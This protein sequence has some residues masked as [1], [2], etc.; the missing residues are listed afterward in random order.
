M[1]EAIF[2]MEQVTQLYRKGKTT[3][4]ANDDITLDIRRGEI[5]GVLGPNGAGK[6][7]LIKQLVGHL[8]PT[9]G[10]VLYNG[11]DV[12]KQTNTVASEVAYY[13]QEPHV[14]S[15]LKVMEALVF[16]ARLR[17]MEA[18]AAKLEAEELLERFEMTAM[19]EKRLSRLSGGQKRMVGI[20]TT[21]IGHCPVLILD[22]PTNELDPKKRRMVWELIEERNRL[23]ATVILVTHNVLEAEH[24]VD[25]A[26]VINHGRLLAMDSVA[27][28]KQRVD[29]RLKFDIQTAFGLR[30]EVE[31]VLSPWGLKQEGTENRIRLLVDKAQ[32][33][34][35]LAMIISRTDLPIEEYAVLPPS[36]E[37]VYF[38][39]DQQAEQGGAI[40]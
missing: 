8:K 4:L 1:S 6:S 12:F 27:N 7:T 37:D 16:T 31:R 18:K 15:P 3:T 20:G 28:L 14:L 38:H 19:K 13:A 36:L 17:G 33:S 23:G 2:T 26:A 5:L 30:E 40:A 22:E 9:S 35:L 39:I 24:V 21:L 34:E 29:Q 10:R 32:A 25:R 11:L